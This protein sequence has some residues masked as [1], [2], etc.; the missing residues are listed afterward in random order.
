MDDTKLLN[1]I[2]SKLDT[3]IILQAAN[4]ASDKDIDS[5]TKIDLLTKAG[6]S[7]EEIGNLLGLR[8]DSIRR[9][10]SRTNKRAR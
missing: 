9:I 6:F 10:R 1:L 3:L 5:E 2:A 8:G 7:S 4:L